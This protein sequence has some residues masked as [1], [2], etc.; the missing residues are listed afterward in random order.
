MEEKVKHQTTTQ[1]TSQ[2]KT[3]K[4]KLGPASSD[5]KA[6]QKTKDTKN[7]NPIFSSHEI[8]M[9]CR[10]RSTKHCLTYGGVGESVFQQEKVPQNP[11]VCQANGLDEAGTTWVF[12]I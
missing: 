1:K 2:H 9:F 6:K 8:S 12:G 4:S 3:I 5:E 11:V 10:V 7:N